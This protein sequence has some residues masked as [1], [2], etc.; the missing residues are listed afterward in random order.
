MTN[1]QKVQTMQLSVLSTTGAKRFPVLLSLAATLMMG[2]CTTPT[3]PTD[4]TEPEAPPTE[5]GAGS[6]VPIMVP[7][8]FIFL[9]WYEL[10]DIDDDNMLDQFEDPSA[11]W[12]IRK[13]AEAGFNVYFDYRLNSL[14]EAEAL[15]ALGDKTGMKIVV[16]CPELHDATQTARTVE[17]L[18]AHPSLYAYNV[19]DEP[20]LFEYPEMRR[21]IKGI[22][23]YDQTHLCYV[24]LFPNYGWDDWVEDRYLETLRHYLRT[25]PV[26]FLSFDNYPVIMQEGNRVLR[27]AWYHNL[28]DIRTA[29]LEAQVPIWSFAMAKALGST[30]RP[31]LADLRLQHFSNLVYGGV[32]IQYYTTRASVWGEDIVADIYPS[33]KQVNAELKQMEPLFLG[34]DIKDIWHTGDTIPRG[35]KALTSYPAGISRITTEGEGCV[36]SYFTN[37]GKQYIA[38]VNRSCTTET[39]LGIDFATEAVHIAKDGTE[40][41][42]TASYAIEAGDIRIFSWE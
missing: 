33:V 20:E 12:R 24:N 6:C 7:E 21:R 41:P 10:I 23:Q 5:S 4:D 15:L 17:A 40:S 31:T 14:E 29:A 3:D 28:E 34:A 38:F 36:V 25:V 8:E 18:S 30:P 37:K 13:L 39:T 9:S 27:D 1:R 16:E 22:Y 19:W 32:A 11:E 42:A 26:S 35:T 2:A